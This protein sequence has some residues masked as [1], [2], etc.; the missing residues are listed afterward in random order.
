MRPLVGCVLVNWNGWRDTVACLDALA[1]QEYSPLSVVVVDNGS[2][3]NSVSRLRAAHPRVRVI[4]AG[5]NLG[6]SGGNNL[7]IREVLRQD[8]QYVWLLNND[9]LPSA[10][11]LNELVAT[12]EPDP[13]LGAV[14]SVL[15]DISPSGRVQAWGGGWVNLWC[16]YSMHATRPQDLRTPLHFLTAASMLVRRPALEQVGLLDDRFFL[17]WE[18]TEFCFR[19]RKHGWRLGVAENSVVLHK[20]GASA[21]KVSSTTDRYS[22]AS[23][24]RFLSQYSHIPRVCVPLFISLRLL[25]RVLAGRIRAIGNVW[26]GI[27]DYRNRD[28]RAALPLA[29]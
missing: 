3:D 1:V 26:T 7:G 18:D 14:G 27:E 15:H 21:R 28:R 25:H 11:A 23:G 4:E 24:I 5:R 8:A 16:G 17:Y 13:G 9:T 19:L 20:A 12:A 22:T 2:T 6:F 29:R 10:S